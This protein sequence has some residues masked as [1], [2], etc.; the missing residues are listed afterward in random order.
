MA[1][2]Q[3]TYLRG[4]D[5]SHFQ[6]DIDWPAVAGDGVHF[7]FI[8]ATEGIGDVDPMFARNWT[9]AK[10]AGLLR[11]A[12]HF[13]HPN[14][15]A[16]QQAEHFLSVVKQDGDSLPPALDIEVTDGV[17][18]Q[19]LQTG[20]RTWIETVEAATG[21]KP[22]LYTDPSFW[23]E[24]VKADLSEYPL[25]LACYASEPSMP[26]DWQN[27]TFWQHSEQGHVSGINGPVDLDNCALSYEQ[28]Q[29]MCTAAPIKT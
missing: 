20:I 6:G 2:N 13:F 10:A 5:V 7:C 18:A 1:E 26:P 29:H 27:W 16:K 25:W 9:E 12:Y 15:D 21:R 19:D 3:K 4:I 28:L 11:G 24:N 8:K 22:V 23:Q 14:L 17:D